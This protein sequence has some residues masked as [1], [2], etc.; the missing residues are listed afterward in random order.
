MTV[1]MPLASPADLIAVLPYMLGYHPAD[2]IVV[3]GLRGLSLL[4]QMRAAIPA[5]GDLESFADDVASTVS[6]PTVTSVMLVGYGAADTTIPALTAVR[7]RFGDNDIPV[8]EV[9]RVHDGRYWSNACCSTEC[10]PPE[11][12]PYDP[13]TSIV[14]A[15]ATYDGWVALPSRKEIE[16]RLAPVRGARRISMRRATRRAAHRV[17]ALLSGR[18]GTAATTLVIAGR[19]A[20]DR[21]V[22]R[23]R[24]GESMSDDE[25]AWLTV[26]LGFAQVRDYAWQCVGGNLTR[27]IALWTEV[28]R[29]AEPAFVA[30]GATLLAFAAWRAGEGAVA[31]IALSRALAADPGYEM[32]V[33][34][35]A[36]L[37]Q[38]L[39]P[40]DWDAESAGTPVSTRPEPA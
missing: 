34:L 35:D 37:R 8:I 20:V 10:C 33:L 30:P 17:A 23:Q 13:S 2:D 31:T 38:G 15:Q 27:H 24:A 40:A 14:A 28:L 25:L 3:V 32:A 26:M 19:A 7:D 6:R 5:P 12:T 1:P 36:A 39:S 4:F 21:A 22:A 16:R 11:G 18:A 29:H 9:L